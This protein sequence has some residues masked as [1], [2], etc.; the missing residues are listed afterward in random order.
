MGMSSSRVW[1][2]FPDRLRL[3]D[4]PS[5]F[6]MVANIVVRELLRKK[7]LEEILMRWIG[8]VGAPNNS[9]DFLDFGWIEEDEKS[10]GNSVLM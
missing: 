8:S 10:L 5:F 6:P 3:S 2:D 9:T 7:K 1:R 4:L